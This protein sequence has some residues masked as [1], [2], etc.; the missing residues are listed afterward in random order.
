MKSKLKSLYTPEGRLIG[1]Y[2]PRPDI[3][4]PISMAEACRT[5]RKIL[6]DAERGRLE[7]AEKEA[8]IHRFKPPGCLPPLK[9]DC[10]FQ[11]FRDHVMTRLS[12][13]EEYLMNHD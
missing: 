12:F 1:S 8:N 9:G 6:E 7:A 11:E 3:G 13:I 2:A 5:A 10:S 4:T